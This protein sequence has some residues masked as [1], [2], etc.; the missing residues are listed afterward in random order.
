MSRRGFFKLIGGFCG[1]AIPGACAVAGDNTVQR[2]QEYIRGSLPLTWVKAPVY[3][4]Q[5]RA[6]WC[7]GGNGS[8]VTGVW[9]STPQKAL[10][11]L[12]SAHVRYLLNRRS[13]V[14]CL[15][16]SKKS[17]EEFKRMAG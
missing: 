13:G 7:T 15:G 17:D 11:D 2:V 14:Q 16:N 12:L 6:Y 10:D 8:A 1:L 5:A 3:D 4:E 9:R